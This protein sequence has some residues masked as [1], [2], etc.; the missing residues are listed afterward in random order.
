MWL[1]KNSIMEATAVQD[2]K[3]KAHSQWKITHTHRNPKP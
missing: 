3:T 2:V 1:G